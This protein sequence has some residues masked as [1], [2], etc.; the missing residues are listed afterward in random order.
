MRTAA[1]LSAASLLFCLPASFVS[2]AVQPDAERFC[3]AACKAGVESVQFS[4]RAGDLIF[5]KTCAS[6]VAGLS[7]CLCLRR[8]CHEEAYSGELDGLNVTCQEQHDRVLPS[9]LDVANYTEGD[10]DALPKLT[11]A[12]RSQE[13]PVSDVVIPDHNYQNAWL[14][15]LVSE[16]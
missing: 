5:P 14:G 9:F 13:V 11:L 16:L 3:F 6:R 8:Y 7:L 4:D 10:I 1:A 15:T 12:N 2:A